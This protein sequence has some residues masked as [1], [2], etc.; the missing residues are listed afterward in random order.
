[1]S[2]SFIRTC[3][4]GEEDPRHTLKCITNTGKRQRDLV[5]DI[6]AA[7]AFKPDKTSKENYPTIPI[8]DP[9]D[10]LQINILPRETFL[11]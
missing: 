8:C 1:M 9:T 4:L 11:K 3:F 7:A 5:A 6:T 2:V 10:Y